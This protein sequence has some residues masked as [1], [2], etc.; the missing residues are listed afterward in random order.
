[1]SRAPAPL[2]PRLAAVAAMI[3]PGVRVADVGTDHGKLPLWLA[4]NG[5][6]A[7]CLATEKD[8]VLLSRAARAPKSAAWGELLAY[9]AGDGLGAI[10]AADRIHT[11]VLAGMGG[12]T[13]VRLLDRGAATV[14]ALSLIVLQPRSE[15]QLARTWLARHGWR[16]VAENLAESAGRTHL[17]LA[18]GRGDDRDLYAHDTLSRDDLLVAGPILVRA[19]P[20]ELLGLWRAERTRLASIVRELGG[21]RPSARARSSLE[22]AERV[23]RA[24][25]RRA[26]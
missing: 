26:E 23:L 1:M 19:A 13:I 15:P 7:F 25:S 18:A 17:T 24:I 4:S 20:P 8:S 22:R 2:S 12:R 9:R 10:R 14:A 3:P 5:R 11:L 21:K 16:P 6:V